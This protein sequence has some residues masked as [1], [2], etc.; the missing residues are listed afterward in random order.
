MT[1]HGDNTHMHYTP[2]KRTGKVAVQRGCSFGA[3]IARKK[4]PGWNTGK[5]AKVN[6]AVER[7]FSP[8]VEVTNLPPLTF[9]AILLS[10]ILYVRMQQP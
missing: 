3:R 5:W 9:I 2:G 10:W 6:R 8:S 1:E 7:V 4:L